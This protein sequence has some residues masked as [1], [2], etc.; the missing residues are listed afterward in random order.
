MKLKEGIAK[1]LGSLT[2]R[3][4]GLVVITAMTLAW[5]ALDTAMKPLIAE[6][7]QR[8][9]SITHLESEKERI[10]RTLAG[11]AGM[12]KK[13]E[14]QRGANALLRERVLKLSDRL[15]SSDNAHGGGLDFLQSIVSGANL[16]VA[17]VNIS[18]EPLKATEAP[19]AERM[20]APVKAMRVGDEHSIIRSRVVLKVETGFRELTALVNRVESTRLPL[21]MRRMDVVADTPGY[22]R[23]LKMEIEMDVFSL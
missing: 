12:T 16:S 13:L 2:R 11:L 1:R 17:E 15:K 19:K 10:G 23:V 21:V 20:S 14:A 8:R 9:D 5:F 22:P 18:S 4:K 3:E 7:T 6:Y